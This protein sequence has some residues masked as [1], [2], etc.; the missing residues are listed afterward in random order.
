MVAFSQEESPV[1]GTAPLLGAV[2]ARVGLVVSLLAVAAAAWWWTVSHTAGMDN[3]PWTT[4]G[5]LDWFTGAWVVMMAAMMLPSVAPTVALYGRL[6]R[7][8]VSWVPLLFASGYL[9]TW[10]ATGMVAFAVAVVGRSLGGDVLAWSR[11]GRWAAG[12]TLVVAAA[13]ELSPLKDICLGKCRSPLSFL[14]GSWRA[15]PLGALQMGIEHG[16][17]CVGCCWALMASLFALGVMSAGW[18]A[19]IG[20]LIAAEKMLP[21]RR[22]ARYGIAALLVVLGVLLLADPGAIPGLTIPHG[23]MSVTMAM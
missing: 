8:R 1:G 15:G 3:G 14:R 17:W 10:A 12:V 4:L 16:A 21:W 18:M 6:D 13:Y 22:A 23:S 20:L 11:A 19:F 2:R 5:T 7:H 9:L